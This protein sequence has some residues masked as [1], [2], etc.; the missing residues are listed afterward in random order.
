MP[1]VPWGLVTV[2]VDGTLTRVHGWAVIADAV[3]RRPEF[4][5]TTRRF[6]AREIGE[7]AHLANTLAIATGQPI[8]RVL[9]AVAATPRLD[10]IAEGVA[11]LRA[12][13][14]RAA[15][16]TH[17]PEYIC[18]WYRRE[19]GF[20]DFD[21]TPVPPIVEGL[22][23]APGPVHADKALGLRR[24]AGRAGVPLDR[25]VHIGDGWADAALFPTVGG[26]IALNSSLPDVERAA[27]LAIR[28]EDFRRVVAAVEGL[29]P[30]A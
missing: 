23:P 9:A 30:R 12:E 14:V 10:G 17:N 3:G 11:R 2:D 8:A 26:G 29:R 27:D 7:D 6:R 18:A 16:L 19:F 1:D 24:L 21:G 20:D 4:D 28:T 25:V 15:L 5:D 22:I 13:G